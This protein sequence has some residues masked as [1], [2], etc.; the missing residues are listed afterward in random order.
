MSHHPTRLSLESTLEQMRNAILEAIPGAI[1]EVNGGGG[2]F[3]ISVVSDV[4]EG[5]NTLNRQRLVYGAITPLMHGD[6]AP[7][8]AV[9]QMVTKTPSE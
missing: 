7:V 1:V 8:H 5:K 4:F 3:T 6:D 9:D 2:H